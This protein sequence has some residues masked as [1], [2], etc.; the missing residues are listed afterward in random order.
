MDPT[1]D[2]LRA[3]YIQQEAASHSST[4]APT[5]SY[6][7]DSTGISAANRGVWYDT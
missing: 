3:V 6:R 7:M 4:P 5:C 1:R 2:N